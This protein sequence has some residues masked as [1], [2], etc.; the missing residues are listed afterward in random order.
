MTD[1]G[2]RAPH[3]LQVALEV[4]DR[5]VTCAGVRE[6]IVTLPGPA[7]EE[8]DEPACM[9]AVRAPRRHRQRLGLK[10]ALV[11]GEPL[12]RI[13]QS[14]PCLLSEAADGGSTQAQTASSVVR[15]GKRF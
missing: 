12:D 1:A 14:H 6:R 10:A 13:G 9:A 7:R 4:A 8:L 11:A 15:A 3:G 5:V 2:L